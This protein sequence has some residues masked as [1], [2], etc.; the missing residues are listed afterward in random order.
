MKTYLK[1]ER[2][3]TVINVV[4]IVVN[5]LLYTGTSVLL[6]FTT[7]AIFSRDMHAL[8][9]WSAINFSV[10]GAFLLSNYFQVV[11][12]EKLT[13]RIMV[14]IRDTISRKIV[15]SSYAQYHNKTTGEY[16]SE[17]VNDVGN[18][19]S[20]AIKKFFTLLSDG[21]TVVF[22]TITLAAYHLLFIPAILLLSV[23]MLRVPSRLSRPMTSATKTMSEDNAA[24]SN[25]VTNVLNGFDVL[26]NANKLGKLHDLIKSAAKK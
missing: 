25:Q 26:F 14:D 4:W 6:T 12:Q 13:Q 2:G 24:F 23:L 11:F 16:L 7:N 17:Y 9:V 20:N 15:G 3:R 5:V 8:L 22:S 10:W 18:I 19:E 21:T 1:H